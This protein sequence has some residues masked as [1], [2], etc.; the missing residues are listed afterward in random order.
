MT[1]RIAERWFERRAIDDGITHLW[2]PHVVPLMR[3]DIWHV[4]G[5]SGTCSSIRAWVA[6]LKDAV[7][8]RLLELIDA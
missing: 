5:A 3:C 7:S 6:S 1:L 2:E 8:D 4:R